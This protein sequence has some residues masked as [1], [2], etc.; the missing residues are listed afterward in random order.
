MIL[1]TGDVVLDHNIYVGTRLTPQG[2]E[3]SLVQEIP[4]GALLTYGFLKALSALQKPA[5]TEVQF[6]LAQT[7]T[8]DLCNWPKDFQTHSTWHLAPNSDKRKDGK[9]WALDRQLGYGQREARPYP[10]T[11]ALDL[12]ESPTILVVDDAGLGF[13]GARQCWP[14]CLKAQS[15]PT[16][17]EWV[18]LKMSPPLASDELWAKLKTDGWRDR[19]VTIV[20][21]D[22]LRDAGLR[23]ARGLSWETTVIDIVRELGS[24]P[25]LRP[26]TGCRHLIV[27]MGSE[28]ALW[29]FHEPGKPAYHQLVFDRERCEGEW[30]EDELHKPWKAYGYLSAITASVAWFLAKALKKVRAAGETVPPDD[31]TVALAAGLSTTRFLREAGHGPE[32]QMPRFPFPEAAAHLASEEPSEDPKT[33]PKHAYSCTGLEGLDTAT[34]AEFTILGQV[35]WAGKHRDHVSYEPARRVA[36]FGPDKLLG[37]PCATFKKYRTLDRREIDSLRYLRQLMLA[38]SA[39]NA[40]K[41]PLCLAV[42][43]APGSGKSFGLKQIASAVFPAENPIL[44]FN[45]SQYSAPADLVGA[46]HQVRDKALQGFKPVVF[47][48]EFD[49]EGLRW[50]HHFLAPMQDGTFQQGEVTH[51]L[52]QCVFVFAGGTSY[53]FESFRDSNESESFRRCKGPD[54]LSRLSGFLNIAGPNR[55]LNPDGKTEQATDREFPIRR[56]LLIRGALG[57][58]YDQR[59]HIEGSLLNALLAVTRYRNGARSLEKLVTAIRDRGGMPLRRAHIPPDNVLNLYFED[60]AEF[61]RLMERF[62]D[63]SGALA[64]LIHKAYVESLTSE[65]QAELGGRPLARA[66]DASDDQIVDPNVMAAWRIPEVLASA[67]YKLMEGPDGKDGVE[68]FPPSE[69]EIMADTE[70]RGWEESKRID[71][72]SYWSSRYNPAKRH[73]LLRPYRDLSV[74]DKKQDEVA[75]R[76]YPELARSIGYRIVKKSW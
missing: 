11:T 36:C 65:Q 15:R 16:E 24:D 52:G 59:L 44:E 42:F 13:R 31:L 32:G 4:G 51:T 63:K 29:I 40:Q 35:S 47:W 73:H 7:E 25:E 60:V 61:H 50:L 28:A 71:G 48:D 69:L 27:T 72:W 21:A 5:D 45:V 10:A 19:V 67:G 46:Y 2:E 1:V 43:G 54:F 64:Q 3:G 76:K 6:G 58:D 66:W 18:I 74:A 37:V 49:S 14:N 38:Y 8:K 57:L 53:N 62:Q 55:R 68:V 34:S 75:I 56:A 22:Q 26:L 17:P 23:V 70:H 12:P 33:L 20:S 30:E 41:R 39:D 9:H